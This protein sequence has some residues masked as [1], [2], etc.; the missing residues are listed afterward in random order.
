MEKNIYRL[1]GIKPVSFQLPLKETFVKKFVKENG[2]KKSVGFKR[3]KYV[4]G[5][6]SIFAE[7][8]KGD[9]QPQQIWFENGDVVVYKDDLL[10]NEIMTQHP[11]FKKG[12]YTLWSQDKED[13]AKLEVQRSKASARQ[14]IDEAD[15]DKITAIALA[16]FGPEA[17]LW[18]E[19][20]CEL[21]LREK[22]DTEPKKLKDII[23]EKNY[24][25]KLLAGLAFV[26]GI[27]K[28]NTNK[29]A[30]VWADSEGVILKLAKGENGISELGRYLGNA[31]EESKKVLQSIGD[32]LEAIDTGTAKV[33]NESEKDKEIAA[34]KAKLA[35]FEG[36]KKPSENEL[37]DIQKARADYKALYK[38]DVPASM[39]NKLDWILTKIEEAKAE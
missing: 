31:N 24:E 36:E 16:V 3:I 9:L 22:A 21:M 1:A 15:E 25:S 26:K 5:T 27:V 4:P 2:S 17:I 8:I 29:T 20:K 37:S 6:E 30:V 34:L 33:G 10:L 18:T 12:I 13:E 38:K 19:N 7:D 28:E 32:R 39:K 23:G 35:A 11:W 14:L